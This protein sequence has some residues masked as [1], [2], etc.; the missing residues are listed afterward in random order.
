MNPQPWKVESMRNHFGEAMVALGRDREDV[1]VDLQRATLLRRVYSRRQL[2]E[3][4]V[5]FWTDHFNIDMSKGECAWLKVADD[6]DVIRRHA[7]GRFPELA[8]AIWGVLG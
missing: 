6:R 3:R 8:V 5:E 7:L 2:H 4:M 1:V